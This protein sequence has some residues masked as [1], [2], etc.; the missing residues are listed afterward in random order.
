M[1]KEKERWVVAIVAFVQVTLD[2]TLVF[3]G[4]E[5]LITADAAARLH[6]WIGLVGGTLPDLDQ[7]G[8]DRMTWGFAATLTAKFYLLLLPTLGIIGLFY[9]LI[10]AEKRQ[11]MRWIDLLETRDGAIKAAILRDL[12]NKRGVTD[13]ES[14]KQISDDLDQLFK[15]GG[16]D[17]AKDY[18]P[19]MFDRDTVDNLLGE[20]Q[21]RRVQGR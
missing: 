1:S 19:R 5:N 14:L 6:V 9:R 11:L 7:Y 10:T 21:D 16:E 2:L 15:E 13:E 20:L 18:L 4:I 3:W 17:W 12:I 8:I